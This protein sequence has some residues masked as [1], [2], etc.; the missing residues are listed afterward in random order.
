MQQES[1]RSARI[2]WP[3]FNRGQLVARLR[4]QLPELARALPLRRVVLFGS[5][6]AGRATAF[7][8]VDVLVVYADPPRT[9][10]FQRVQR[11]LEVRG[12]EP[13]VYAESEAA[14]VQDTLDRMTRHGIDLLA[15]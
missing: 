5:W 11:T 9:D 6:A 10:A 14:R 8:D 1:L 15:D 3:R 12:L 2:F 7:S 13:H 4:E